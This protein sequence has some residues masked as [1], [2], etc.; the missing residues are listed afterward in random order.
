MVWYG[1]GDTGGEASGVQPG[2]NVW[3]GMVWGTRG[4]KVPYDDCRFGSRAA[5][6]LSYIDHDYDVTIMMMM[7][8]M[9]KMMIMMMMMV[10]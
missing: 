1:M 9:M 4:G 10:G 2:S 8:M 3:Y 6:H 7:M 5:G